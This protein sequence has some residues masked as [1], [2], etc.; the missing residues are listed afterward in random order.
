MRASLL[1]PS[2]LGLGLSGC[3]LIFGIEEGQLTGTGASG[4]SGAGPATGGANSG[5]QGGGGGIG[6][7]GGGGGIGGTGGLGGEGGQGGSTTVD[8][9]DPTT[10]TVGDVSQTVGAQCGLF[11]SRSAAPGGDGSKNAPFTAL[12]EA[13]DAQAPGQSI[14]VTTGNVDGNPA[15]TKGGA[16]Y[17]G[18]TETWS[19][20]GTRTTLRATEP[21]PTLRL[22]LG[23]NE[24]VLLDS[25]LVDLAGPLNGSA[26]TLVIV[27]GNV[28]LQN[29]RVNAA[30]ASP[31]ASGSA[32]LQGLDGNDGQNAT[33]ACAQTSL[34]GAQTCGLVNVSGGNG[35]TCNVGLTG[36]S[37]LGSNGGAGG[38]SSGGVCN[39]GGPGGPGNTGAPGME[40]PLLGIFT[41][42]GYQPSG[43]GDGQPG[44]P[45]SGGGGGSAMIIGRAG[46]GG[47]S[48][49]CGGGGGPGGQNGGASAAIV[50][51]NTMLDLVDTTLVG[52]PGGAGAN[53]L[54]GAPGGLSGK[55][56]QASAPTTGCPGGDGGAGGAGGPGAGGAGGPAVLIAQVG[57]EVF[58]DQLTMQ[59]STITIPPATGGMG[60][61][62]GGLTAPNG[63]PGLVCLRARFLP[64]GT[65]DSCVQSF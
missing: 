54:P 34:G 13:F 10:F 4:G 9:C 5:G 51:F 24:D 2:L 6:G 19:A 42:A 55:G 41:M 21:G 61:T 30:A 37:G 65:F 11:V 56:G 53:G 49:A 43:G 47:G 57:G 20:D 59:N 15:K 50:A 36:A 12:Q 14:Y 26:V 3:N 32:P 22:N 60:A 52:A 23:P 38:V 1:L 35:S 62:S 8:E 7:T 29:S 40:A 27:G 33:A 16:V 58:A 45:G 39:P 64:S 18:L 48:G 28:R 44:S 46:A 17:G 63:Q 25:L 31:G